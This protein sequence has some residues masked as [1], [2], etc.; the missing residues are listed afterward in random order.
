MIKHVVMKGGTQ[1]SFTHWN[2]AE[3]MGFMQANDTYKMIP[4]FNTSLH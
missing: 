3:T 2:T 4:Q 1:E